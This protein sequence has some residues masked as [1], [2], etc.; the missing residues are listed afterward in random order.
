MKKLSMVEI[1]AKL[2]EM[3]RDRA[4]KA[5]KKGARAVARTSAHKP[6][7]AQLSSEQEAELQA[8]GMK[9]FERQC[10]ELPNLSPFARE[11]VLEACADG[12]FATARRLLEVAKN[13]AASA[14][15]KATVSRREELRARMHG[16]KHCGTEARGSRVVYGAPVVNVPGAH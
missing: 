2:A 8:I 14:P 1:N 12:D 4:A 15:A 13:Q 6:A 5:K 9:S 10:D 16:V 7:P 3:Q 11:C